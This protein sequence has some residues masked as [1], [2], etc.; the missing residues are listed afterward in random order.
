M[1]ITKGI[2]DK[3][4]EEQVTQVVIDLKKKIPEI[5]FIEEIPLQGFL[6]FFSFVS[7]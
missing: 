6:L 4:I 2:I 1:P 3:K 7:N 5:D